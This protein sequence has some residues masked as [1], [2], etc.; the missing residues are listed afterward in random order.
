[1]EKCGYSA[2]K[3]IK[4]FNKGRGNDIERENYLEHLRKGCP[5]EETKPHSPKGPTSPPK[6]SKI[7]SDHS[8]IQRSLK[9]P[10]ERNSGADSRN[11][12]PH[13]DSDYQQHRDM[14]GDG[15]AL[16]PDC[17]VNDGR[18]GGEKEGRGRYGKKIEEC[19]LRTK[20][21]RKARVEEGGRRGDDQ[22]S[23]VKERG[24]RKR[25]GLLFIV[26]LTIC[27]ACLSVYFFKKTL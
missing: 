9:S 17:R 18:F 20:L 14:Y 11:R 6:R 7:I 10:P 8:Y 13:V 24:S 21:N 22:R 26:L 5:E 23:G 3:A 16:H 15:A 1:M 25:G 27:G 12:L 19:D 2:E 4:A